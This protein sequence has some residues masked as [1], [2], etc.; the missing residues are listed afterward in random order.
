MDITLI[1]EGYTNQPAPS[2]A[3]DPKRASIELFLERV[4]SSKG[5][6]DGILQGTLI[7]LTA[8][9]FAFTRRWR[10]VLPKQRM[11]DVS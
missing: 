6:N 2:A 8:V 7:E 9:S 4:D 10:E 5:L 11:I 1:E 3:L